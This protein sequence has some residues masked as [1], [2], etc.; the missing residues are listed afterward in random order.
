MMLSCVCGRRFRTQTES[1]TKQ[2]NCPQCGGG[3]MPEHEALV[4]AIDINVL[5]EQM[6]VLRDELVARDRQLRRAQAE[7]TILKAEL[8]QLRARFATV[9]P[10][11][12]P[13]VPVAVSRE[14]PSNRVPL[15]AF[16]DP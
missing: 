2:R 6:K 15:Y 11:S 14:M 4:P 1:D 12:S 16:R 13:K 7:N 8:D 10:P 9:Q 3:L 5:I